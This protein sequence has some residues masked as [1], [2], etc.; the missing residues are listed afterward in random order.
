MS[1]FSQVSGPERRG[2]AQARM[3]LPKAWSTRVA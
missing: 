3:T 2:A 1:A